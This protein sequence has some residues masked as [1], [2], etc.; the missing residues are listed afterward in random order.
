MRA[1]L[2]RGIEREL[3]V[4]E[5]RNQLFEG[6]IGLL[7]GDFTGRGGLGDALTVGVEQR[8][9][10]RGRQEHLIVAVF[11]PKPRSQ[12]QVGVLLPDGQREFPLGDLVVSA[13]DVERLIGRLRLF[14]QGGQRACRVIRAGRDVGCGEMNRRVRRE[15]DEFPQGKIGGLELRTDASLLREL[16]RKLDAEE[17]CFG[18]ADLARLFHSGDN[19]EN[20]VGAGDVFL[21]R[22]VL[23]LEGSVAIPL[24][25]HFEAGVPFFGGDADELCLVLGIGLFPQSFEAARNRQ[26]DAE[27]GGEL[28]RVWNALDDAGEIDPDRRVIPQSCRIRSSPGNTCIEPGEAKLRIEDDRNRLSLLQREGLGA[29]R[30]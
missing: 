15:A 5:I 26:R 25:V 4:G 16:S 6:R 21:H 12:L 24:A 10:N 22:A 28:P 11:A 30:H 1:F 2:R 3:S 23:Q 7:E 13:G 8:Q 18:A 9:R 19:G 17:P 20:L 14:N 27:R 29:R